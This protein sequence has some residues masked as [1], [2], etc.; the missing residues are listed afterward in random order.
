MKRLVLVLCLGIF[1]LTGCR[2][3]ERANIIFNADPITKETVMHPS[4]T[5]AEGQRI[6][7]LFFTPKKLKTEFIRVQVFTAG[8]TINRGGY[9]IY[10]TNDYRIM[11]QNMYYYYNNFTIH[12]KGRYVMQI[13]GIDDLGKPLAFNEFFVR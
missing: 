4:T 10:W 11:K 7:Y 13:F 2:E 6:Y 5:F 12:K 1:F 8:D 3:K 9:K